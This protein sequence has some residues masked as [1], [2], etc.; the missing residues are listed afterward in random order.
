M[1]KIFIKLFIVTAILLI[2]SAYP[3]TAYSKELDAS[4]FKNAIDLQINYPLHDSKGMDEIKCYRFQ[5]TDDVQYYYETMGL[6]FSV[7]GMAL[8]DENYNE[9]TLLKSEPQGMELDLK[10]NSTYYIAI[11]FRDIDEDYQIMVYTD[12][13][14]CGSTFDTGKTVL[15]GD[16]NIDYLDSPW[17]R[18]VFKFTTDYWD[19]HLIQFIIN[20][21]NNVM[22]SRHMYV[23]L[24]D[25]EGNLIISKSVG[26]LTRF[27]D[28]YITLKPYTTYYLKVRYENL[29]IDDGERYPYTFGIYPSDFEKPSWA[30]TARE[31]KMDEVIDVSLSGYETKYFVFTTPD[32]NS[33]FYN[34]WPIDQ[35]YDTTITQKLYNSDFQEIS[36][37]HYTYSTYERYAQELK[38][39]TTYYVSLSNEF[40]SK[41][42]DIKFGVTTIKDDLSEVKEIKQNQMYQFTLNASPDTDTFK[43][44]TGPEG[45]YNISISVATNRARL[46]ASLYDENYHLVDYELNNDFRTLWYTIYVGNNLKP[47][48]TYY[49]VV[50]NSSSID[51]LIWESDYELIVYGGISKDAVYELIDHFED[52]YEYTAVP[53]K[54]TV[55]VNGKKVSFDAYNIHGNNYFKLHDL[56]LQLNG[57]GKQFDVQWDGKNQVITLTSGK[58]YTPVGG[59]MTKGTPPKENVQVSVTTVCING[60]TYHLNAYNIGGNNYYKLRDIGYIFD[61]GVDWDSKTQTVVIDTTKGYTK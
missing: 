6:G 29:F 20:G 40:S 11:F 30:D 27:S 5:T 33:L 15:L 46:T 59:E 21:G 61:F 50:G 3:S 31:L 14:D 23:D 9:I 56:A 17:D 4:V 22:G 28:M 60:V 8:Y 12:T 1:K 58:P 19:K 16:D 54:S 10:P 2:A 43:F 55:L 47:N 49:L 26:G 25:C 45:Y 35:K 32:D 41:N 39:N 52:G 51:P 13:D 18:D 57:T 7:P 48:K 34:I 24:Y 44:T 36:K 53:T 42:M 38:P 37:T